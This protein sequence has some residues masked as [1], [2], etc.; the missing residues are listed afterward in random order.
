MMLKDWDATEPLL[1]VDKNVG[2]TS[3]QAARPGN[4]NGF[5]FVLDRTN[6]EALLGKPSTIDLG[7]RFTQEGKPIPLPN[8]EPTLEGAQ[9]CR[10]P[11]LALL[12]MGIALL[13]A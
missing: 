11:E 1:L 3:S 4:R 12:L 2:G 7:E 6:G 5:F 9:G 8:S 13:A 10:P